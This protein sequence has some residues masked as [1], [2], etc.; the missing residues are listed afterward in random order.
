MSKSFLIKPITDRQVAQRQP[1]PNKCT[2]FFCFCFVKTEETTEDVSAT[3]AIKRVR[4]RGQLI[5]QT[6]KGRR[7]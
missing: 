3:H 4:P 7:T 2:F 5:D 6:S 1:S